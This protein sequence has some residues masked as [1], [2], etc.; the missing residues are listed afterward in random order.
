MSDRSVAA[1]SAFSLCR[2]GF[3]AGIVALAGITQASGKPLCRPSLTF[4]D[5][6]FSQMQPPT[7][8]RKW[9][10]IVAVDASRCAAG[11]NGSFEIVFTRLQEFG[12]D[13][14]SGEAFIWVAPE[15]TVSVTFAPTEAVPVTDA[16]KRLGE[17]RCFGD[18]RTFL[19]PVARVRPERPADLPI[20]AKQYRFR[21]ATENLL[22]R[23]RPMLA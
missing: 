6:T 19:V 2:S 4:K 10:A 8:Q 3:L 14:E 15:V 16:S 18:G 17:H 23:C 5:V 9:T 7:M 12:P 20:A 22:Q 21:P 11:S 13:T 1:F